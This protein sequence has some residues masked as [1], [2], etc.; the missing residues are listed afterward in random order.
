LVSSEREADFGKIPFK[1]MKIM[2]KTP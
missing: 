1:I 2:G